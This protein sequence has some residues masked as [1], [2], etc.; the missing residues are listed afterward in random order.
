[1]RPSNA[2]R[3]S[4]ART[5]S[6]RWEQCDE[7]LQ[8]PVLREGGGVTRGERLMLHSRCDNGCQ[9]SCKATWSTLQR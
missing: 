3:I 5:G 6:W 7:Y 1:M 8:Q 4:V 2:R 9:T